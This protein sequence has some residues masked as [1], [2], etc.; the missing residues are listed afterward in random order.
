MEEEKEIKDMRLNRYIAHSGICA[1]RKADVFIKDGQVKVNGEVILEPGF[2]VKE[3]DEVR[4]KGAVITPV[5]N[6]VYVLMNKPKNTITTMSDEKNRRTVIDILKNKIPE[7]IYPVGRLD[8]DTVGLLL[9]TN[10]GILA[11]KLSHPSHG[12]KKVYHVTLD[13]PVASK[14]IEEIRKGLILEDGPVL[15]GKTELYADFLNILITK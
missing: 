5:K 13:R 15:W 12:V 6:M 2:R 1:R 3:N 8:K 9:L 11:K 14:H 7:R 10:D 4:F